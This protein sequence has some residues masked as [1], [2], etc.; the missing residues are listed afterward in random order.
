[1]CLTRETA[2]VWWVY[3]DGDSVQHATGRC[4]PH[5]GG[6]VTVF[7][8]RI[9]EVPPAVRIRLNPL[10]PFCGD[11]LFGFLSMRRFPVSLWA[12]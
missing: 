12:Y 8:A 1:M 7:C 9:V 10:R 5:D 11:C 4:P 3:S 2:C 6:V